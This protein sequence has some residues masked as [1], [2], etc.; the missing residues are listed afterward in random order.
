MNC[1]I[2][3]TEMPFRKRDG[4]YYFK[5]V[6]V[7]S[8]NYLPK[9]HK[10]QY[11]ALCPLCSARYKEFIKKD[12][13]AMAI[14]RKDLDNTDELEIPLRLGKLE[15]SILF[16]AKHFHDLRFIIKGVE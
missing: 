7:F 1:Q 9:E 11:L 2:C 8:K 5:A 14:L 10:A 3:K 13:G 6:E 15:T 16:D 12:E 4:E